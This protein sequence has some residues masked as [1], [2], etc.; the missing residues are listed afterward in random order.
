M[1]KILII[2]IIVVG[3]ISFYVWQNG[4]SVSSLI[5]FG[6]T[7]NATAELNNGI[8]PSGLAV[9]IANDDDFILLDVRTM[10]EHQIDYIEGSVLIP[11]NFLEDRYTELSKEKEI[12]IYC[13]SGRRSVLASD[14]LNQKGFKKIRNLTG[15]INAWRAEQ[16]KVNLTEIEAEHKTANI[17]EVPMVSEIPVVTQ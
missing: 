14:F 7:V 13:R 3:A 5:S 15:G 6:E 2:L 17:S 9:K 16:D 1:S 12:I 10:Q 4:V 8:E 11:L